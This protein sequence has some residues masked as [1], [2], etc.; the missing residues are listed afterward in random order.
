MAES[1]PSFTLPPIKDNSIGWGPAS[2]VLPEQFRDIPYAPYSKGDKLGRIADW[3]APETQ[4][5]DNRESSGRTGRQGFNRFNKD[6]Y[7]SYGAGV[8]SAFIYTH[9]E[10]EAS[11]SVVDNRSAAAKKASAIKA[12]GGQRNRPQK[13]QA[14]RNGLRGPNQRFGNQTGRG[15]RQQGQ[16][17]RRFGWKDYDKP[18]RMRDASVT[19]GPEWSVL[20]EIE[21]NRLAKLTYKVPASTDIG[22]YGHINMYDKSYDRINTRNEKLLQ[23][24]DRVKYDTTTSD[25]P[26]MQQF[27]QDN[28]GTVFATDSILALLMCAPRT[29]YPWDIVITRVDDKVILDK[30]DGGAFDFLT[31]NENTADPPMETEKESINSPGALSSEATFINSSFAAQVIDQNEKIELENPNPFVGADEAE[32]AASCGYRYKS[33]DLTNPATGDEEVE[34]VHLIVRTEVDAAVKTAGSQDL[35]YLT[36]RALNEFDPTAQGAGG[37]LSWRKALDSQR[38]AVVATEMKNNSA[39]LARWAVQA[40]LAGAEQMKIGYVSRASPKDSSRHVVLGTQAYKPRDFM[41]Q[42]NLSIANGWGIIK[43]VVDMC[44]LL[45]EGKYV[46]VKD[47]NKAILRVYSVPDD[48]FDEADDEDEGEEEV[49][50]EEQTEEQK[51]ASQ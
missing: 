15:G 13:Q 2:D 17:R 5:Q 31:V 41:A 42:M 9:N 1:K 46:L 45:S 37:A 40:M 51:K 25:D 50:E 20:D 11:F 4:K 32:N 10:D 28:K 49:E 21:F 44:M 38:G 39:K 36:V 30:R 22:S 14:T 33:F 23:H 35:T 12:A 18:Q 6:P 29:V 43:A 47:P 24:I 48:A 19:V 26:I 7:Q 16:N 27:M 3:S 34:P 8:S